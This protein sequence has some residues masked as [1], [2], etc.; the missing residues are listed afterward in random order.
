MSE[1]IFNVHGSFIDSD[2]YPWKPKRDLNLKQ[3]KDVVQKLSNSEQA[4]Y[5]EEIFDGKDGRLLI[6]GESESDICFDIQ[7][8]ASYFTKIISKSD[9]VKYITNMANI[10]SNPEKYGFEYG[11]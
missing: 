1:A 7:F 6:W 11:E 5:L 9:F 2:S 4:L 3:L 8:G 10:R